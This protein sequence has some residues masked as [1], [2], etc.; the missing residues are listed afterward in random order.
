MHWSERLRKA[1]E[2]KGLNAKHLSEQSGVEYHN[3]RKYVLGQVD[4]PRGD[5][6]KK[7]ADALDVSMPWLRGETREGGIAEEPEERTLPGGGVLGSGPVTLQVPLRGKV[8]AGDW[9]ETDDFNQDGPRRVTALVSPLHAK[10][11]LFAVEV[12]GPSMNLLYAPGEILVC[13]TLQDGIEVR[14]GD[15]VIVERRMKDAGLFEHTVK[16]LVIDEEGAAALWPR[17]TDPKFQTPL[18]LGEGQDETIEGRILG[19]VRYVAPRA[20]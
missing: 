14:S 4:N 8:A 15:K 11:E 5:I 7:M 18:I 17:S 9:S 10:A 3:V 12:E 1:M 16:E 2:A 20:L 19:V 13:Q 6:M